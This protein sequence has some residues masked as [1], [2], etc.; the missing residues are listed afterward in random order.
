MNE[1]I[2]RQAYNLKRLK[3]LADSVN[4]TA[5][6]ARAA[7]ILTLVAA[8]YLTFI[9]LEA[10]D[11]KLFR[12][13][14]VVLPQIETGISLRATYAVAP[15][16]FF[17]LHIQS[18]FLLF[19]L[20]RKVLSFR[21]ELEELGINKENPP[22]FNWLSAF[23]FV[24]IFWGPDKTA[25]LAKF[26]A[27]FNTIVVP[28]VLL[29]AIQLSFIRFQS[30]FITGIH[31]TCLLL[32]LLAIVWFSPY[33][34]WNLLRDFKKLLNLLM[35]FASAIVCFLLF[36]TDA[37]SSDVYAVIAG[38]LAIVWFLLYLI[39]NYLY[40]SSKKLTELLMV[41]VLA[42]VWF[43]FACS[44]LF[45]TDASSSDVY[46]VIAGMLAIVWFLLYLMGNSLRSSKKNFYTVKDFYIVSVLAIAYFTLWVVLP[47][48]YE[49]HIAAG[50]AGVL[51]IVCFYLLWKLF[52]R[53][54]DFSSLIQKARFL[55]S[56][57]KADKKK[58]FKTLSPI[59]VLPLLA[60]TIAP[61]TFSFF[62]AYHAWPLNPAIGE[63]YH[64]KALS[65]AGAK[66][67]CPSHC[68]YSSN[69]YN[70]L[71]PITPEPLSNF[72]ENE[73]CP[74]SLNVKRKVFL[75][76]GTDLPEIRQMEILVGDVDASRHVKRA[77]GLPLRKRN[78]SCANLSLV[79]LNGAD[80]TD[81]NL[82]ASTLTRADLTFADLTG[83]DLTGADLTYADLTYA[84]LA[85]S[86]LTRADLTGANLI[87]ANLIGANLTDANLTYADLF[88][89][90]LTDANLT[91]STLTRADLFFANLTDANLTDANLTDAYLIGVV[92][93]PRYYEGVILN[94]IETKVPCYDGTPAEKCVVNFV[95]E[96]GWISGTDFM[97]HLKGHLIGFVER[98]PPTPNW[99]KKANEK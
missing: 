24:Q 20:Y 28:L 9:L 1:S 72:I 66:S 30:P 52:F 2:D 31:F 95:N 97:G 29:S 11:E 6:M 81:A 75:R 7:I 92:G 53:F 86:N 54:Q 34:A 62:T 44:L 45:K 43:S 94:G 22:Y 90:D 61:P 65:S 55:F 99:I 19:V 32:D 87:G 64:S 71:K 16:V 60:L 3:V 57:A 41:A 59:K 70:A 89:A 79:W 39:G 25:Y 85:A 42:I 67:D 35:A 69:I 12:D 47:N 78:F 50:I 49:L 17:Y 63:D 88:F 14:I 26:I 36:K 33:L 51:T 82:T 91:A 96:M 68:L 73:I 38:M 18:L 83:A 76:F 58:A 15:V 74:L 13:A 93:E 23:G 4:D 48:D 5:R 27:I 21:K 56:T 98:K 84:D 10:S 8:L 46:A 37:S 80:L 40:P 77:Y